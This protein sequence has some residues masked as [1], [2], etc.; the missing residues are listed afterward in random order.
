MSVEKCNSCDKECIKDIE[1]A[2]GFVPRK[3]WG[4]GLISGDLYLKPFLGYRGVLIEGLTG[5]EEILPTMVDCPEY[6][7]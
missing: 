6:H 1:N 4:A 3:N 5:L 2:L 7:R